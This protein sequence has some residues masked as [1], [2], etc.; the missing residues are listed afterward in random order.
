VGDTICAARLTTERELVAARDGAPH[1][2]L[3]N[4]LNRE[5]AS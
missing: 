3:V 1:G 4:D 2:F 5:S